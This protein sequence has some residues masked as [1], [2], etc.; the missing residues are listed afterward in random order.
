MKFMYK[1]SASRYHPRYQ[2]RSSMYIRDLIPQNFA[3]SAEAVPIGAVRCLN[4]GPNLY[5]GPYSVCTSRESS[6]ETARMRIE[7]VLLSTQNMF[8]LM[9]KKIITILRS[10]IFLSASMRDLGAND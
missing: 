7:T 5:P 2:S 6:D 10:K 1:T 8:K 9:S 4:Y 3:E